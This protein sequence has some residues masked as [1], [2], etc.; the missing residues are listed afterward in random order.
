MD[1]L[2]STFPDPESS[3]HH[4]W[5]P[6]LD[7]TGYFTY[8]TVSHHQGIWGDMRWYEVPAKRIRWFAA[9]FGLEARL[10]LCSIHTLNV[11]HL[12]LIV[13]CISQGS[14]IFPF[15]SQS[16]FMILHDTVREVAIGSLRPRR[17]RCKPDWPSEQQHWTLRSDKPETFR[18]SRATK[19]FP[20]CCTCTD[21]PEFSDVTYL[22]FLK[23]FEGVFQGPKCQ[24]EY[25]GS[26][27]YFD[28]EDQRAFEG[29]R[30]DML[31]CRRTSKRNVVIRETFGLFR[32]CWSAFLTLFLL[33][34]VRLCR[35]FSSQ[36]MSCS[37]LMGDVWNIWRRR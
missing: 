2:F 28:Q 37:T 27:Q 20:A 25:A 32:N 10:G 22:K 8:L 26:C 5:Q 30:W 15:Y 14:R 1:L 24:G 19:A 9:H 35:H 17:S 3:R 12:D 31:R 11:S 4:Y 7:L 21:T 33:E 34:T 16:W 29:L 6:G 13:V 36:Q 23:D 18:E